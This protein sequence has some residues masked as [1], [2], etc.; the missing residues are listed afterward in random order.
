MKGQ[1]ESDRKVPLWLLRCQS[2]E[3]MGQMPREGGGLSITLGGG[4]KEK[5]DSPWSRMT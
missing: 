4:F 2:K 5:L 1:Q 3:A